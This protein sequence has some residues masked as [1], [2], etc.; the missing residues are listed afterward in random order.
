MRTENTFQMGTNNGNIAK[1]QRPVSFSER[2]RC[3]RIRHEA[4]IPLK[5]NGAA[6]HTLTNAEAVD[7]MRKFFANH[8]MS[9]GKVNEDIVDNAQEFDRCRELCIAM[10]GKDM[11]FNGKQLKDYQSSDSDAVV[12]AAG[13]T[14]NLTVEFIRPF[15]FERLGVRMDFWCPGTTQMRQLRVEFERGGAFIAGNAAGDIVQVAVAEITTL[16]DTIDSDHDKWVRLP[17]IYKNSEGGLSNQG[18]IGG[19]ALLGIWEYTAAAAATALT[20]FS[21]E[22][23]GDEPIHRNV[24]AS[25]VARDTQLRNPPG[26]YDLSNLVT[27]LFQPG[28]AVEIKDLPLASKVVFKMT[29]LDIQPAQLAYLYAPTVDMAYVD[30]VSGANASDVHGSVNQVSESQV[31]PDFPASHAAVAP[32]SIIP[33][34]SAAFAAMHGR[35]A[36]KNQPG[37]THIPELVKNQVKQATG[38]SDTKQVTLSAS[39]MKIA[40]GIPG[41]SSAQR[42]KATPIVHGIAKLL[43]A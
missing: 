43:G 36:V 16:F 9:F 27:P 39:A 8:T 15:I 42:G 18:P 22:R 5:N 4:V 6:S 37:T 33:S 34:S 40:A 2:T 30:G 23:E 29:T 11:L 17:R 19:G 7:L 41:A 28:E 32:I 3:E 12:I 1:L 35:L 13:A 31:N 24:L 21:I 10:T 26:V 14:V 25:R 38:S 20:N